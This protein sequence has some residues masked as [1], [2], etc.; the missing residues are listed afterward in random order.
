M[1]QRHIPVYL[2]INVGF[3]QFSHYSGFTSYGVFCFVWRFLL[4]QFA[5]RLTAFADLTELR[6]LH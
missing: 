4:S 1:A 6:M 5:R 3:P 2:P